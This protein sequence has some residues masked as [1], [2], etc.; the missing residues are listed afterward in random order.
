MTLLILGLILFFGIHSIFIVAPALRDRLEAAMG[1]GWRGIY[2]VISLAGFVLLVIG[3][4]QARQSPV[5]LYLPPP[6]MRHLM[7]TLMLFVFPLVL[8][9]ALPAGHIKVKLKHPL[10]AAT[11]TWALAHLLVNGMLADVLLFGGFLAWAVVDRISLKRREKLKPKPVP[12][13]AVKYDV[14][15]VLGG[16]VLFVL[17]YGWLHRW[18]AGVPLR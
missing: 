13:P 5:V 6:W 8:A 4:G 18:I 10:L 12:V 15:A 7:M 1:K 9:S 3:Y 11:K 17:T 14:I 2:S 16:L